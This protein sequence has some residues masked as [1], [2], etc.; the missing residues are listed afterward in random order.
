VSDVKEVVAETIDPPELMSGADRWLAKARETVS[1]KV[2][3]YPAM[4]VHDEES[5]KW[6]KRYRAAVR[7]DISEIDGDRKRVTRETEEAVKRFREG[8]KDVLD[9]LTAIDAGYKAALDAYEHGHVQSRDAEMAVRYAD[10]CPDLAQLVPWGTLDEKYGKDGKWHLWGTSD[11][12]AWQSVEQACERTMAD[13]TTIRS[14][15]QDADEADAT[16]ADYCASLDLAGALR[17]AAER[18]D[19]LARVKAAEDERR[20]WEEEQRAAREAQAEVP[21]PKGPAEPAPEA[22]VASEPAEPVTPPARDHVYLVTVPS[23]RMSAF[24]AAMR[25]L[26][27][28]H[29][30]PVEARQ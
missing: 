1:G 27:G 18:R 21:E 24:L 11:A 23:E 6:A 8:C 20:R 5:H 9:P 30:R 4:D 15:A 3:E 12:K 26:P 22:H 17:S 7:R 10:E 2:A 14:T 13:I 19:R 25:A 16:I 29:G 28:V